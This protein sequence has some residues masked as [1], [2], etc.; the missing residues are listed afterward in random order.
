MNDTKYKTI[1]K[2]FFILVFCYCYVIVTTVFVEAK[3]KE[4]SIAEESTEQSESL[5]E[6]N[7]TKNTILKEQAKDKEVSENDIKNQFNLNEE[8]VSLVPGIS[9]NG[10]IDLLNGGKVGFRGMGVKYIVDDQDYYSNGYLSPIIEDKNGNTYISNHQTSNSMSINIFINGNVVNPSISGGYVS[11]GITKNVYQKEQK[12]FYFKN[13]KISQLK[14]I[15]IT[16]DGFTLEHTISIDYKASNVIQ[17]WN[18]INNTDVAEKMAVSKVVDMYFGDKL[19]S[20]VQALGSNLGFYTENSNLFQSKIASENGEY[21]SEFNKFYV[22]SF[23]EINKNNM[24]GPNFDIAGQESSGFNFGQIIKSGDDVG[25]Q[26]GTSEKLIQPNQN[27]VA[28]EKL[29]YGEKKAPEVKLLKDIPKKLYESTK[30]VPLSLKIHDKQG[31]KETVYAKFNK[32]SSQI[33]LGQTTV[34][35]DEGT[36]VFDS[37]L[38]ISSLHLGSNTVEIYTINNDLTK[39]NVVEVDIDLIKLFAVPKVKKISVGSSLNLSLESLIEEHNFI[40]NPEIEYIGNKEVD[41]FTPG[42]QWAKI[43]MTDS[44]YSN[45]SINVDV[46]INIYGENTLL[47]N[48]TLLA[49]DNYSEINLSLKELGSVSTEQELQNI[50][51]EKASIKAWNMKNGNTLNISIDTSNIAKEIGT[52]SATIFITDKSRMIAQREMKVVVD[53]TLSI[54]NIPNEID[55]ESSEISSEISYV[56]KK[57]DLT[58]SLNT[59]PKSK[60]Y[61]TASVSDFVSD[62]GDIVT[63]ILINK[64]GDSEEIVSSDSNTIIA[65]GDEELN[66]YEKKIV[67]SSNSGLILKTYPGQIKARSYS[68]VIT[69]TLSDAPV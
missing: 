24:F 40:N 5:R 29:Y 28:E 53:A 27:F 25:Y 39:S 41:T 26:L 14:G 62:T 65:E 21:F 19:N 30:S 36:A 56:N 32:E 11:G 67:M 37:E 38:D 18:F 45:E 48:A 8:W 64:K 58:I 20:N 9:K 2:I 66:D 52:Y 35:D 61:L 31:E 33:V 60:W 42:F 47:F 68:A 17:S 57:D 15:M 23:N 49:I 63:D 55:F 6:E 34:S 10:Y 12:I 50:I 46:P 43:K 54:E 3:D 69:W 16:K 1:K 7:S 59:I 22:G 13:D 51:Q 4:V 44:V